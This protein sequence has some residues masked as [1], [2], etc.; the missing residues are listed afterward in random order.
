MNDIAPELL[1]KVQKEFSNEIS[2]SNVIKSLFEKISNGS[3]TY[4][5]AHEYAI[6]VGRILATAY[7]N[8]IS[9]SVLPDGKMY[10][11][12]AKR[13]IEPTMKVNYELVA[14][15][16]EHVQNSLNKKANIGIKAIK[17][18]LNQDKIDGIV[19]RLASEDTYDDVAWIL[20]EPIKTFTQSIV[21]DAIKANASFQYQSGMKPKII[22]TVAGNC[23]K[24]CQ[25]VA[26]KYDYPD[27][28]EDVYRRHNRCRCI[29]EYFPGNGKVQNVHSKKIRDETE[30]EKRKR[31]GLYDEQKE[32]EKRIILSKKLRTEKY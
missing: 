22:R 13:V 29:V 4:A 18:Q 26:G 25:Q 19:S 16:A 1:A 9:S 30:I 10:Y 3:A 12:I 23:C 21:D 28:P 27:V 31:I 6:E 32:K 2:K 15:V 20:D 7:K 24:W 5:E 11:N 14:N 8:N 17:P